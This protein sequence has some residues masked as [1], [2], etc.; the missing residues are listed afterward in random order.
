MSDSRVQF[1]KEKDPAMGRLIDHF[2]DLRIERR[3][4]NFGALAKIVISQQLSTKAASSIFIRLKEVSKNRSL[5][6][7]SIHE[8]SAERV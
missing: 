4:A 7:Q 1:L 8:L 3:P 2:G 6:P 5:T